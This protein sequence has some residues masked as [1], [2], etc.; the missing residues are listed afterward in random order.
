M[1]WKDVLKRMKTLN[2]K[3]KTTEW[4]NIQCMSIWYN[5]NLKILF[6]LEICYSKMALL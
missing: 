5:S 1:F 2:L 4:R 3:L 6:I